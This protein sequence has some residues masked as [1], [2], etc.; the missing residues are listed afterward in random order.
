MDEANVLDPTVASTTSSARHCSLG[1]D[2]KVMGPVHASIPYSEAEIAKAREALAQ[3]GYPNPTPADIERV[4]QYVHQGDPLVSSSPAVTLSTS[5]TPAAARASS[6]GVPPHQPP[7][8]SSSFQGSPESQ[9][10]AT[11][12]QQITGESAGSASARQGA[13]ASSSSFHTSPGAASHR[14]SS[15]SPQQRGIPRGSRSSSTGSHLHTTASSYPH[16]SRSSGGLQ[17]H[18]AAAG[19]HNTSAGGVLSPRV[20]VME[21]SPSGAT[22]N[23]GGPTK[24][25][26]ATMEDNEDE[27]AEAPFQRERGS[28]GGNGGGGGG[29][30]G[31]VGAAADASHFTGFSS[32]W[33]LT[34]D[35]LSH[36]ANQRAGSEGQ[37]GP[38]PVD[39]YHSAFLHPA[40]G[41]TTGTTPG[42][43]PDITP[44]RESSVKPMNT[45]RGAGNNT[46]TG[47][48]RGG[49]AAG[50]PNGGDEEN[51][52]SLPLSKGVRKAESRNRPKMKQASRYN[53]SPATHGCI[54]RKPAWNDSTLVSGMDARMNG[55]HFPPSASAPYPLMPNA[56]PSR[57]AG[58]QRSALSNGAPGS[59]AATVYSPAAYLTP[60]VRLERYI[61]RYEKELGAL[62]SRH[63]ALAPDGYEN[64][65]EDL[66]SDN[67]PD[68]R[69]R[70]SSPAVR[71]NEEETAERKHW[72]DEDSASS[73]DMSDL[74]FH[75]C[76]NGVRC[77]PSWDLIGT[78]GARP[79]HSLSPSPS[80]EEYPYSSHHSLKRSPGAVLEMPLRISCA[81]TNAQRAA[82][83]V[84]GIT[85]DPRY[86]FRSSDAP[87]KDSELG[88]ERNNQEGGPHATDKVG[89]RAT[90]GVPPPRGT[91]QSSFSEPTIPAPFSSY[92]DPTGSTLRRKADPVKRGEQMRMLWRRDSFLKTAV[93]GTVGWQQRMM[94]RN[95]NNDE[96]QRQESNFRI[97][98]TV[99]KVDSTFRSMKQNKSQRKDDLK[100]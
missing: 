59:H 48:L 70:G 29:S 54:Q 84:F 89:V 46:G 50:N 4:L 32:E 6:A 7:S 36:H 41:T 25:M 85:G 97:G 92:V 87:G 60:S 76:P 21:S 99:T 83:V 13:L 11:N 94:S 75:H 15:Q 45:M 39:N 5:S 73:E 44:R 3:R 78:G 51:A 72:G 16:Q 62:Y 69:S 100:H 96:R 23:R 90:V 52:A 22:S 34:L 79:R 58:E 49:N 14:P 28:G 17:R 88:A 67:I 71:Q 68:G 1:T 77:V 31:A 93:P 47:G 24:R 74:F 42:T 65:P 80:K 10:G 27:D 12:S 2:K 64:G 98:R 19:S 37:L 18:S 56:G 91:R 38:Y 61:K 40:G 81:A 20:A 26:T 35:G 30:A 86:R 95:T 57:Y 9:K 55:P 82:N 8:S 66:H 63:P 43:T 53:G 33:M